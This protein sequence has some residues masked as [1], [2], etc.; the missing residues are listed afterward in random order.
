MIYVVCAT[1]VLTVLCVLVCVRW[2]LAYQS[3]RDKLEQRSY[4]RD[5][6]SFEGLKRESDEAIWT[7][8]NQFSQ[9]RELLLERIQHPSNTHGQAAGVGGTTGATIVDEESEAKEEGLDEVNEGEEFT[10]SPIQAVSPIQA[11]GAEDG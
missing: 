9:E 11:I 1:Q 6:E 10:P 8:I 5:R 2:I 7:L 4:E 3:D